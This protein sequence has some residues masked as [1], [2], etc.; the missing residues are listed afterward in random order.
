MARVTAAEKDRS[1]TL[2]DIG[3]MDMQRG[4]IFIEVLVALGI[5]AMIAVVFLTAIS[6]GLLSAGMIEGR[7]TAEN[8]ARTQLE[9]IKS[10]PYD[11]SNYYPVTVSPPPGYTAHISV[12]DESPPEYPNSLQKIVVSVSRQERTLLAVETYKVNR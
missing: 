8:L 2:R 9:D 6:S 5:M 3:K 11:S 10:L 4:N 7:L 12:T 1:R